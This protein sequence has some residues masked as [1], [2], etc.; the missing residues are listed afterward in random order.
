MMVKYFI[1]LNLIII[2]SFI[3][4]NKF[5]NFKSNYINLNNKNI[6]VMFSG[7]LD[8]VSALYY[9]LTK[10][11]ANLYVHHIEIDDLNNRT[12]EESFYSQKIIDEFKNKRL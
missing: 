7:G 4:I 12:K 6:L 1:T 9:L 2:I 3:F 10:T 5:K 8:S 11:K